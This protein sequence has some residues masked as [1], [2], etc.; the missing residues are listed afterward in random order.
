M[1]IRFLGYKFKLV[2]FIYACPELLGIKFD[3]VCYLPYNLAV[4][5]GVLV[6][7]GR[8]VFSACL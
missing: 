4:V 8:I 1:K 2:A 3:K 6:Y 5:I 7:Y